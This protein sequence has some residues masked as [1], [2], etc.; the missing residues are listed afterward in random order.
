MKG[1]KLLV[2]RTIGLTPCDG[3]GYHAPVMSQPSHKSLIFAL[4]SLALWAAGPAAALAQD[5]AQ[6][7]DARR[8]PRPIRSDRRSSDPAP[9]PGRRPLPQPARDAA[10]AAKPP[11]PV[12]EGAPSKRCPT[13][14]CSTKSQPDDLWVRIRQGFAHAG[15]RQGR[16]CARRRLVRG[17]P[18]VPAA[19][20]RPQPP[21]PLPHRRRDREARHA[22]RARAAADGGERVQPDGVLARARL[23]PVAVHSRHRQALR[24][25]AELLV[26]R[27]ARHR[28]LDQRRARLPDQALRDARRLAPRARLLQLGRERGGARHRQEPGGRQAD[29][30][31]QPAMPRGD[32]ALHPEAAGAEEHHRQPGRFGIDARPDPEPALLRDR[33]QDSA[34][35]TCSS[36][37]ASPRCRS[38]SSSRSTRASAGR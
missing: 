8:N 31:R 36:P 23:R 33:H 13:R 6:D 17:A 22:D 11:G 20:L 35:S 9:R 24:A 5:F 26:R 32:A 30:L 7:L 18:G 29:R 28:R 19:H 10:P 14:R 34:T 27:A 12:G 4:A 3:C 37:R 1:Q 16:W 2:F 15:P 38:R 21:L 25:G